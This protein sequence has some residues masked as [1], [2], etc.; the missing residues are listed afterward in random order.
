MR[1]A[2]GSFF[3]DAADD[4]ALE[5]RNLTFWEAMLDHARRDGFPQPPRR[6]LDIGCHRG[7]LLARISELW[8]PDELLGIEPIATARSRARLRLGGLAPNVQLYGPEDWGKVP[9]GAV[10]LVVCHEVLFLIPDLNELVGN[11]ARVLAPGGRAY[12]ATGCHAENPVWPTWQRALEAEG[13]RTFSHSPM[14]VLA[15]GSSHGLLASVRPLRE[16]GWATHD[17]ADRAFTFPTV[18]ALLDHQFRH[19][20]LFRLV[21]R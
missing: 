12:I 1:P 13:R 18:A 10:D 7:G 6:V 15:L 11:L 3:A 21:R 4:D 20:L 19:K 16:S 14:T 2:G 5:A 17:P 9:A 8:G